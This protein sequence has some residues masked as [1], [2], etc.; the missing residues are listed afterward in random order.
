LKKGEVFKKIGEALSG[1]V[2]IEFGYV[3]GSFLGDRGLGMWMWLS[4]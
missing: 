1:F 3:F 4:T 2:E